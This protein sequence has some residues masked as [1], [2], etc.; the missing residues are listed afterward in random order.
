MASEKVSHGTDS[1]RPRQMT[2]DYDG[3]PSYNK[4]GTR[5]LA[6]ITNLGRAGTLFNRYR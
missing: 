3:A 5:W 1:E 6:K 4:F 2:F